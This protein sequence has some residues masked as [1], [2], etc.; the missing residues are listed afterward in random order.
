MKRFN[1]LR[2]NLPPTIAPLQP[3]TAAA[4]SSSLPDGRAATAPGVRLQLNLEKNG[5]ELYFDAKPDEAVRARIKAAGFRWGFR[6]GCWYQRNTPEKLAW[7]QA[8]IADSAGDSPATSAA[9]HVASTNTAGDLSK[10]FADTCP[11]FQ[12]TIAR[13]AVV[14]VKSP[15]EVYALWRKYSADCQSGDQSPLLGEFLEWYKTD[16]GDNVTALRAALET[17][18]VI[19]HASRSTGNKPVCVFCGRS[20]DGVLFN[21]FTPRFA[22]FGTA[23]TDCEASLPPGTKPPNSDNPTPE[24]IEKPEVPEETGKSSTCA[25]SQTEPVEP[26]A[27]IPAWRKYGRRN[28]RG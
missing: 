5:I 2:R 1:P 4:T 14:A 20:G 15:L 16:L 11:E 22:P 12:A 17:P 25:I 26:T 19:P 27:P 10:L 18:H 28:S 24:K 13:I 7:A 3:A 9:D 23:C 21:I 6:S 8:F